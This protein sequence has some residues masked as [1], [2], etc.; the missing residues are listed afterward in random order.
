[1]LELVVV[2]LGLLSLGQALD[3]AALGL[4]QLRQQ[5]DGLNTVNNNKINKS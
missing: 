2:L 1:M 4:L 5:A 3:H